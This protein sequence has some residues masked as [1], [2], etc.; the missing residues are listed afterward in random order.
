M[1]GKQFKALLLS[2]V[3][4]ACASTSALADST[5]S[6]TTPGS[7]NKCPNANLFEGIINKVCWTCM[8]P[9]YLFGRA[10]MDLGGAAPPV[11][12]IINGA[13][14]AKESGYAPEDR[15]TGPGCFCGD[16][17]HPKIGLPIGFWVPA[18]LIEVT[19][20]SGCSPSF[21]GTSVFPNPLMQGSPK[22]G[23]RG[24]DGTQKIYMNYNDY[25]FPL[26]KII[27]MFVNQTCNADGYTNLD[28]AT[29]SMFDPTASR[30]DIGL[31]LSPEAFASANPFMLATCAIQ[32][33]RCTVD[34][35]YCASEA[36]NKDF[37]CAGTWG[38]L[39]PYTDN[40]AHSGSPPRDTSLIAA[41]ILAKFH[42]IGRLKKTYGEHAR[43]PE[44]RELAPMLPKNQ[45]K[46]QMMYPVAE[47]SDR[48]CHS[49]GES[50]YKWGEW[51][52]LPGFEDYVYMVWR[53]SD[54][55]LVK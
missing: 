54:C 49:I 11:N 27:G 41:R 1:I 55:C 25:V 35:S 32:G 19:R 6:T 12:N 37:W 42:R 2:V 29:S 8:F 53:W 46:M 43:C 9:V 44:T 36:Y 30:D 5:T 31:F 20:Q 47:S 17:L 39:T 51:R 21:G 23:S 34:P 52:N 4:L 22:P 3:L 33:I 38:N 40:I 45:Y 16:L 50:T 26:L 18:R 7:G 24:L 13:N 48:C 10:G 15:A 28:L 14:A